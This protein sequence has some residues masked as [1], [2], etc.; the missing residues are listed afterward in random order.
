M[1]NV[2]VPSKSV[3][4]IFILFFLI[5]GTTVRWEIRIL[6]REGENR[7]FI[8][9]RAL[10][11]LIRFRYEPK[12]QHERAAPVSEDGRGKHS[13]EKTHAPDEGVLGFIKRGREF[14]R[15]NLSYL[16]YFKDKIR[17]RDFFLTAR[18]GTGDAAKTAI[19]AASLYTL[20]CML[21]S[22]LNNVYHAEKRCINVIPLFDR[23][24]FELTAGCIITFRLGHIII[25]EMKKFVERIKGGEEIARASD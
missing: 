21:F 7:F 9:V 1:R 22:H 10:A 12:S 25:V 2:I 13:T 24:A 15:K 17:I 4:L 11:G 14:Y 3:L 16:V 8:D 20:S 19:L 23:D 5:C 6:I 18:I